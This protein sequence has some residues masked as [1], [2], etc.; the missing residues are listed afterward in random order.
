MND[1]YERSGMT[2]F[3][4]V[5]GKLVVVANFEHD[6]DGDM[7]QLL[8]NKSINAE[9]LEAL[10]IALMHF[11]LAGSGQDGVNSNSEMCEIVGEAIRK[12]Q[13]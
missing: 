9:L 3:K 1:T 2:L 6:M 11:Q 12:A 5:D 13:P 7:Q 10:K 8:D 4:E